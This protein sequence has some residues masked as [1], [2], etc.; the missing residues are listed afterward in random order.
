MKGK[1]SSP[2]VLCR[3]VIL[4]QLDILF[5]LFFLWSV[6]VMAAKQDLVAAC[7][8]LII[9]AISGARLGG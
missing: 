7:P 2:E 4:R 9:S 6:E 5:Q 8:L 1:T 3:E